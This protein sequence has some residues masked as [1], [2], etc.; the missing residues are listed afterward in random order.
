MKQV[1][2]NNLKDSLLRKRKISF[3]NFGSLS[4]VSNSHLDAGTE[5]FR[6]TYKVLVSSSVN[7]IIV[8]DRT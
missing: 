4:L 6:N 7:L 8:L 3:V 5:N 1:I 2:S